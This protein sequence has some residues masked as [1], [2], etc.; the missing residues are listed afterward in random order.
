MAIRFHC[1]RCG[2]LLA[3]ASRKAGTPVEC[4]QCGFGQT[5]PTEPT[6]AAGPTVPPDRPP[7]P[8]EVLP[9]AAEYDDESSAFQPSGHPGSPRVVSIRPTMRGSTTAPGAA[10]APAPAP[11]G[12]V[13]RP[14]PAGTILY[15]RRT[16]Y[17]HGLLF[18]LLAVGAFAA[19]YFVGRG[20]VSLLPSGVLREPAAQRV[21]VQGQ[22]Y[23]DAAPD[24]PAPDAGA[25]IV[26]LPAERPPD[27]TIPVLGLR[28]IDP[29]P[30]PESTSVR[31]IEQLGGAYARADAS[32]AFR[33]VLPRPGPYRVLLISR[34][35]RRPP[36]AGAHPVDLGEIGEY[37][38]PPADLLGRHKYRWTLEP[39]DAGAPSIRHDF[40]PDEEGRSGTRE[41]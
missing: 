11:S 18:L 20:D 4:P 3:I 1:K 37:F 39:I 23:Y 7:N 6:D 31:R 33:V 21:L 34:Q 25:V 14:M 8:A 9:N 32:G 40:G 12:P 19:G 2:R 38:H 29:P 30:S 28:P 10:L 16:L 5:V 17:L 22:L 41:E 36:E 27:A 13:A 35:A 26:A 15:R 24:R